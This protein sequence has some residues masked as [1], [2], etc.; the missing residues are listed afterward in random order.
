MLLQVARPLKAH[1]ALYVV[2]LVGQAKLTDAVL[3]LVSGM[4]GGVA[5]DS[6]LKPCTAGSE[7]VATARAGRRIQQGEEP[8]TGEVLYDY[9]CQPLHPGRAYECIIQLVGIEFFL[10]IFQPAG[11]QES[12]QRHFSVALLY[13]QNTWPMAGLLHTV[14]W[15]GFILDTTP[16]AP[17]RVTRTTRLRVQKY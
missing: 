3:L 17:G 6:N 10:E 13:Y 9:C 2:S 8:C 7:L 1:N 4:A 11:G 15:Q 5:C 12:Q 16:T 14:P